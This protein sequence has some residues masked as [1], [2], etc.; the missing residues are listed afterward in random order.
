MTKPIK[1]TQL[2]DVAAAVLELKK[3]GQK[4]DLISRTLQRFS[5][6]NND[7]SKEQQSISGLR[8]LLAEDNR[9]N[10]QCAL[11]MLKGMECIVTIAKNGQI[12]V[13][14][15]K[16]DTFDLILMDCQMPE[17]DGFEASGRIRELQ[18]EALT[19]RVPI[20]ALTANA[21]EGDRERCLA[22]GMD[23]YMTKPIR[24]KVLTEALV[25]GVVSCSR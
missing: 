13:D 24:K 17:M 4:P 10:Q 5:R 11:Q 20:L 15:A 7:G 19:T 18:E 21:M 23:D 2:L 14:E 12:A 6:V 9:V 16:S 8:I 1:T 22:A 3:K 25:A